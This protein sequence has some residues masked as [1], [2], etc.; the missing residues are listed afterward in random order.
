MKD[1]IKYQDEIL[2]IGDDWNRVYIIKG[3][4]DLTNITGICKIRDDKDNLLLEADCVADNNKLYVKIPSSKSLKIPRSIRKGY[5][6]V[7]ITNGDYHHKLV[8]G[9][10]SFIHDISLH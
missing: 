9:G 8:M 2:H 1:T 4:L 7:F 5:Y 6:D 10:F 3:D